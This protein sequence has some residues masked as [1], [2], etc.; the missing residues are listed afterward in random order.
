MSMFVHPYS[1]TQ[2]PSPPNTMLS[3]N[4]SSDKRKPTLER[5][6][7]WF[8][9]FV[10]SFAVF[11]GLFYFFYHED[12]ATCNRWAKNHPGITSADIDDRMNKQLAT[13]GTL[14]WTDENL[15]RFAN[16]QCDDI[17]RHTTVLLTIMSM[18]LGIGGLFFIYGHW[19][20]I[21]SFFRKLFTCGFTREA[22]RRTPFDYTAPHVVPSYYGPGGMFVSP[23]PSLPYLP[24]IPEVRDR[25]ASSKDSDPKNQA[26]KGKSIKDRIFDAILKD[27]QKPEAD[28]T[29]QDQD[30]LP[31]PP[32]AMH[33]FSSDFQGHDDYLRAKSEAFHAAYQAEKRAGGAQ[34]RFASLSDDGKD[35]GKGQDSDQEDLAPALLAMLHPS[36]P[37]DREHLKSAFARGAAAGRAAREKK[38]A[39]FAPPP[40]E[41]NGNEA[42]V[43]VAN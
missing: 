38:K 13:N 11:P 17:V 18:L 10:G 6:L 19:R 5:T 33:Q 9:P 29:L 41:G 28:N 43:G 16:E 34:K 8:G 2:L 7:T 26:N 20:S 21:W 30:V 22:K 32:T 27:R 37:G 4:T 40:G 31:P 14:P 35:D 1:H 23:R 25:S 12:L 3:S 36:E 39:N 15:F 24:A 42:D